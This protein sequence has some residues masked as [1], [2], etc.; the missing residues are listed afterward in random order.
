MKYYLAGPMT[1][2]PQFNFPAFTDAAAKLRGRGLEI[3][4]PAELDDPKTRD[5]ALASPDGK[6]IDGK[7]SGQTW[8]EFLARDVR[9]VA[10]QVKGIIFLPG[11]EDSKGAKLEAYVGILC[12]HEF[13]LYLGDGRT[14]S[15]DPLRV[16][17]DVYGCTDIDYGANA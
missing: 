6:L 3:I 11:W 15:L 16:L 17:N 5:D 9:I 2:I 13:L 10:D 14:E 12:K 1:G 7:S 4:S 8:G